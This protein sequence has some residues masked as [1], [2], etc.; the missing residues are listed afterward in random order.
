MPSNSL[1]RKRGQGPGRGGDEG[2]EAG[3]SPT[4]YE[5]RDLYMEIAMAPR[6]GTRFCCDARVHWAEEK[7]MA[8]SNMHD[9]LLRMPRC[10][11]FHLRKR[12]ECSVFPRGQ[13]EEEDA[14][15]RLQVFPTM[16][17]FGNVRQTYYLTVGREAPHSSTG[18]SLKL[19]API[20]PRPRLLARTQ[21][22]PYKSSPC[23][24]PGYSGPLQP[25][26]SP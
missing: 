10:M 5:L 7:T 17:H 4:V 2:G 8:G 24:P 14:L 18:T 19:H 15:D 12:G 3:S 22:I 11:W 13:Y 25:T 26:I 6:T 1:W 16:M 21:G 20:S 9:C 23:Y